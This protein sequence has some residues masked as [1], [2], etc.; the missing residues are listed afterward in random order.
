MP[1]VLI[2]NCYVFKRQKGLSQSHTP[3]SEYPENIT[4]TFIGLFDATEIFHDL[5]EE[6]AGTRTLKHDIKGQCWVILYTV[7]MHGLD[8]TS[9]DS[10][11]HQKLQD[12]LRAL[13]AATSIED[14]L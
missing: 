2:S 8:R 6:M 5:S 1:V 13:Y 12:E 4:P 11:D 9:R 3:T 10:E 14:L 7:Y